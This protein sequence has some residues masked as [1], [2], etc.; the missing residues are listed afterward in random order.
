MHAKILGWRHRRK[1]NHSKMRKVKMKLRISKSLE[2]QKFT[3]EKNPNPISV[4]SKN[5]GRG[6]L[7]TKNINRLVSRII[8]YLGPL[9]KGVSN[10]LDNKSIFD[11]TRL[12]RVHTSRPDPAYTVL[13]YEVKIGSMLPR[14]IMGP[15]ILTNVRTVL[16][17]STATN[18]YRIVSVDAD[19]SMTHS[20]V[21]RQQCLFLLLR[22][23]DNCPV[24]NTSNNIYHDNYYC[25]ILEVFNSVPNY[26]DFFPHEQFADS[27]G[28]SHFKFKTFLFLFLSVSPP[29]Q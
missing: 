2:T 27:N 4:Q 22:S 19:D 14:Q 15:M 21:H 6:P 11:H 16:N 7:V 17:I 28:I 13:D 12:A 29:K 1:E 3:Q 5:L 23:S 10:I 24:N 8:A 26:A 20:Q 18:T 9:D 25:V